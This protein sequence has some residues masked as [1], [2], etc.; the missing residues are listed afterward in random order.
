MIPDYADKQEQDTVE[1]KMAITWVID[2][3]RFEDFFYSNITIKTMATCSEERLAN[4]KKHCV[5]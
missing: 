5:S 3:P 1:T 4:T 2:K